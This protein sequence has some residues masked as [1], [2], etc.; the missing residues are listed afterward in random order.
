[1]RRFAPAAPAKLPHQHRIEHRASIRRILLEKIPLLLLSF[2]SCVATL[3]AQR[4]FIDPI[5]HLSLMNRFSNAAVATVIY[6]R[7]LVW[8]FGLSVFY[9]HPRHSLSVL[10]VLVAAL[11]LIAVS[12]AAFMYR[13]RNPYF[14]TGWFWFLGMLVP[15][16]GI[17][18]VGDQAHAD[19]YM[20]MP[21]IGLYILVTWFV[22]HTV[23]SWRHRRL[24]LGTAMA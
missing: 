2:G 18:Q 11:F 12:A 4:H 7:Q 8:P 6:L 9:P 1:L 16:S 3:L 23:S 20:Y 22:A 17:I 15:V 24:L 19:R 5:G 14:L 21:Q 13:R 10:Q